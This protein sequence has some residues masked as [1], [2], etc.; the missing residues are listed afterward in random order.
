MFMI[1]FYIQHF[2]NWFHDFPFVFAQS[3]LLNKKLTERINWLAE[4]GNV[5]M[6]R[7][8]YLSFL[9]AAFFLLYTISQVLEIH[10]LVQMAW[11]M[12]YE[13]ENIGLDI[14]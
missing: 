9:H 6:T 14:V 12:I 7:Q 10:P 3:D 11:V 8:V 2:K 1:K 5:A 13:F 4:S